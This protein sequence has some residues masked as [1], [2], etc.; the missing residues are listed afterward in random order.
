MFRIRTS[1]AKARPDVLVVCTTFRSYLHAACSVH[2]KRPGRFPWSSCECSS[3][4]VVACVYP[5][6]AGQETVTTTSPTQPIQHQLGITVPFSISDERRL[7]AVYTVRRSTGI[8]GHPEL[9]EHSC[10]D[11]QDGMGRHKGHRAVS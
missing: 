10:R 9:S 4:Y 2:P 11:E 7:I 6:L 5:V 1:D 3:N 8:P